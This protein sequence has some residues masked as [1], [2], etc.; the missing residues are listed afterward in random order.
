MVHTLQ[1]LQAQ[2]KGWEYIIAILFLVLFVWFWAVLNHGP[3]KR[4]LVQRLPPPTDTPPDQPDHAVEKAQVFAS[5][6]NHGSRPCWEIRRCPP[7]VRNSCAAYALKSLPCWIAHQ[8]VSGEK[9]E[10][11]AT[12]ELYTQ[13]L[14]RAIREKTGQGV[15]QE[16]D[17]AD[18]PR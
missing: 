12:C 15:A 5:R 16:S 7:V 9:K 4:V 10:A 2:I 3:R 13:W 11:C 8:F 17:L 14:E 18:A 6:L 1:Q